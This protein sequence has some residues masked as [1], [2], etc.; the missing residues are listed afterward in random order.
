M[1]QANILLYCLAFFSCFV[2]CFLCFHYFTLKKKLSS[3]IPIGDRHSLTF[4]QLVVSSMMNGL[5]KASE[6]ICWLIPGETSDFWALKDE[7]SYIFKS[8]LLL[9]FDPKPDWEKYLLVETIFSVEFGALGFIIESMS[10]TS[11]CS[12][13]WAFSFLLHCFWEQS[14]E[15]ESLKF[16]S[17]SP[18]WFLARS[19]SQQEKI[20]S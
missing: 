13:R 4:L 20:I 17:R 2:I 5:L 16:S 19:Q 15:E 18:G 11:S 6:E 9:I 1:F 7:E 12:L 14:S 3:F 8:D 10:N